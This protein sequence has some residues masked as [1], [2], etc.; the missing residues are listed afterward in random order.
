[1]LG[2]PAVNGLQLTSGEGTGLI[3]D[4]RRHG[5]AAFEY[6]TAPH[7]QARLSGAA[8]GH[9][10]SRGGRQPEGTGAGHHQYGDRPLQG[11]QARTRHRSG[12]MGTDHPG[13][14]GGQP[15]PPPGSTGD[16]RQ[17]QNGVAEPARYPV[18]Q[19]LDRRLA[20]LGLRHQSRHPTHPRPGTT[21][22]GAQ[23]QAIA[24]VDRPRLHPLAHPPPHRQGFAGE[25][26][27][28][29]FAL[30]HKDL[31]IDR[32]AIA[33]RH[34]HPITGPQLT[35]VDATTRPQLIWIRRL[36]LAWQRQRRLV[37]QT[38]QQPPQGL[39]G[40]ILSPLLEGAAQQ[41]HR[42]QHHRF[43]KEAVPAQTRQ[44]PGHQTGDIGAAGTQADQTVHV[45]SPVAQALPAIDQQRS[46]RPHQSQG[47]Q[48]GMGRQT[49][50][51]RHR[52]P[53]AVACQGQAQQQHRQGQIPGSGRGVRRSWQRRCLSCRI[54]GLAGEANRRDTGRQRIRRRSGFPGLHQ[55]QLQQQTDRH[56]G[57]PRLLAQALFHRRRTT[58][59]LHPLDIEQQGWRGL[60]GSSSHGSSG[61]FPGG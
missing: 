42:Q 1:M 12:M 56:V 6:I 34:Q 50:Q 23:Q 5:G 53:F 47:G 15:Q 40:P 45:G 30:A 14:I 59:A 2:S 26:R 37:R 18:R 7:Q 28:V 21:G 25:H 58:G 33:H 55:G 35:A 43:I 3:E 22:L 11:E 49:A 17:H 48:Q 29:Q 27:F 46:P 10:Q 41:H 52:Q 54:P 38:L 51:G 31:A 39:A 61:G 24:E 20:Q 16:Q 57:D 4:H 60:G 36:A 32:D 8:T 13:R 19:G 9:Q 44:P